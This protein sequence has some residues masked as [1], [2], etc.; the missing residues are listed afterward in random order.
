MQESHNL[1]DLLLSLLQQMGIQATPNSWVFQGIALS[2]IVL[3]ALICNWV[4][5]SI[6]HSRLRK[7]VLRSKNQFDDELHQHGFFERIG[8]IVPAV[9]IYLLS[10][11]LIENPALLEQRVNELFGK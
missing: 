2:G 5:K 7:L 8:H 10:Q 11:L 3:V 4:T 9:V 1:T 6:L